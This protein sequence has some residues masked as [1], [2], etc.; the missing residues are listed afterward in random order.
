MRAKLQFGRKLKIIAAFVFLFVVLTVIWNIAFVVTSVVFNS[1]SKREMWDAMLKRGVQIEQLGLP[2]NEGRQTEQLQRLLEH[3]PLPDKEQLILADRSGSQQTYGGIGVQP[4]DQLA[5]ADIEQVFNGQPVEKFERDHFFSTGLATTGQLIH[6]G[7]QDYALFIRQESPS[8]FHDYG[9][10][11]FAILLDIIIFFV[12]ASAIRLFA[13]PRHVDVFKAISEAIRRMSKGDFNVKIPSHERFEGGFGEIVSSLNDMA[14]ELNQMEQMR[15]EFISNVSHEIQSPLH[16]IGGF[17]R[18]LRT[19]DVTPEEHKHYLDII[20]TESRRLSKL[21]ENLLQ[22]TSLESAHHPFDPR[23]YRLDRQ[24]RNTVLACEPQWMEKQIEMDVS[25]EEVEI[26]ADTDLMSQVWVNL[27]SNSVKFTPPGGTIRVAL[28][29][30]DVHAMVEISD[31]GVGIA[32][33]DLPH[34]FERFYKADK[35]RNRAKGGNG[36]GL[37]IVR[38][39]IEMHQAE[40]VVRSHRGSGTTFTIRMDSFAKTS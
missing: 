16:S 34:I 22:L 13:K 5:R 38:K 33:E 28:W 37:S 2:L 27:I 10:Q 6:W 29:K 4:A 11:L 3:L 35:S 8:L 26:V 19:E 36:L 7:G 32:E 9:R 24:L 20:E 31:S 21:S 17:A 18:A 14:A 23:R 12:L 40:I 25:L 39:I 1:S 30:Q 15:Q